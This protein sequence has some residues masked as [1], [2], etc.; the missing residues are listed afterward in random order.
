MKGIRLDLNNLEIFL[1]KKLSLDFKLTFNKDFL[2]VFIV[3]Q[4]QN[5]LEIKRK[6]AKLANIHPTNIKLFYIKNFPL[7]RSS[8]TDYNKL[9]KFND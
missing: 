4:E 1:K 5:F 2:K 7:T 6:I 3:K 8:K 9:N